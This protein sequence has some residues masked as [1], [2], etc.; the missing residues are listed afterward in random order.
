MKTT[1]WKSMHE[2]K[3]IRMPDYWVM[4]IKE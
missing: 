1:S 2:D 3:S 4:S